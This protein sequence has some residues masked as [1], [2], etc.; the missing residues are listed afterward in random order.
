[1]EKEV[2]RWKSVCSSFRP[3][4]DHSGIEGKLCLVR[5]VDNSFC[6]DVA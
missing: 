1:M 3:I 2:I 4:L 6:Y 5:H